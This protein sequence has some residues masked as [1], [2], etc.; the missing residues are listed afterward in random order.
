MCLGGCRIILGPKV[1]KKLLTDTAG[2]KQKRL[3]LRRK[4]RW[5]NR[6]MRTKTT[7]L[8]RFARHSMF[9][10]RP[11][12]ATSSPKLRKKT[13]QTFS[14]YHTLSKEYCNEFSKYVT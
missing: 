2:P 1:S 13:P 12:I 6:S 10:E 7:P 9:H 5:H 8:M 3:I 11:S 14:L 4:S